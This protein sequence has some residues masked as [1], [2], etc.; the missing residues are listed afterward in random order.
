VQT[1]PAP[2]SS[3]PL[4]RSV[5]ACL[6]SILE[7]DADRVPV[8]DETHPEP[9]TVWRNWLAQRGLGLVPVSEPAG[10]NW[11]GPWLAVLRAA[12]GE[13]RIGAVAFGVPPGLVWNPLGG[14]ETFEAVESG[15]VVAPADVALWTPAR[16]DEP[17][18]AGTVEA[19]VLAGD[20][21]AAMTTVARAAAR[22]GRGLEGD[23][24]FDGRGTFSNTHARGHDL[25]LIEAEVLDALR[26][27]GGR[28]APE[29]ARRN[30]VTR[31][32]DLNALVG[33]R[34]RIGEVECFGRRLCEPCA[35]LERLTA[36]AGKPGTLRALIHKGGLRADVLTDGEI[37]AG[38]DVVPC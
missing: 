25:T 16:R 18:R 31:G 24:Y 33:R 22:A 2:T 32:I 35:H 1:V 27:P 4:Q 13:G 11:P 19:I 30:I 34:F 7:T 9:W 20:P 26:L 28:L 21:E 14:P 6:A 15:F 12:G 23:R 8:P 38:S 36:R 5:A 3:G 17:R 29:E 37:R 10:F